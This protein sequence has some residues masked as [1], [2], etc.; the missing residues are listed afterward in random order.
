MASSV[1]GAESLLIDGGTSVA[2]PAS[3][4]SDVFA[5]DELIGLGLFEQFPPVQVME[6]L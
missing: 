2:E 3:F 4:Q 5:S 1:S 6:D